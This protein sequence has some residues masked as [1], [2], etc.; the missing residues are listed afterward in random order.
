MKGYRALWVNPKPSK[1]RSPQAYGG[2]PLQLKAGLQGCR[3]KQQC[4]VVGLLLGGWVQGGQVI[5]GEPKKT[6]QSTRFE[7]IEGEPPLEAAPLTTF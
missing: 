4:H 6:L 7:I 3:A 5:T 2:A 1:A